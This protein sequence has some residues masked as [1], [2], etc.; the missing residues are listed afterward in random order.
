MMEECSPNVI[1]MPMKCKEAF[2][3]L[4]V[5]YFDFIIVTT[6]NEKWLVFVKINSSDGAFVFLKLVNKGA[7]AIV[8]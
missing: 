3:L 6:R 1:Q 2:S 8:P 4:I 7:C 5:P